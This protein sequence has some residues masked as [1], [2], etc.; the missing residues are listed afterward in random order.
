M[1]VPG[2]YWTLWLFQNIHK[3]D[4]FF[5]K[6]TGIFFVNSDEQQRDYLLERRDLAIDFIFSLVLIEVL[7]QVSSSVHIKLLNSA[8]SKLNSY[9]NNN[10]YQVSAN[11]SN[12]QLQGDNHRPAF[13]N[14]T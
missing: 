10:N 7:K 1:A 4:L 5:L 14:S 9:D 2:I 6:F 8:H 13:G 3:G 11:T 12:H